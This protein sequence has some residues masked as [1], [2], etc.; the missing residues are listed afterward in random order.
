MTAPPVGVVLYGPPCSG[1]STITTAL[2]QLD[3]RFRLLRKLKA[4]TGRADEY[5]MVTAEQL[6]QLRRAGRL[7]IET[8]RY[9]NIYAVDRR[10][11]ED[12]T[13]AGHVP[14]VH[15]G[16]IADLRRLVG[17]TP[18]AWLRVL[19]WVPREVTERR[20]KDRGDTDTAE[21][22]RAWDETL[23]DLTAN[24]G[25]GFFHLRLCTD[26]LDVEAAAVEIIT[27]FHALTRAAEPRTAGCRQEDVPTPRTE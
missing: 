12:M 8:H 4:G 21:R 19:L 11:I 1:K 24:A 10:H 5:D 25:E 22:L 27:A 15:V 26:R 23:A 20:S 9:G 17:R 3:P 18:D 6:D 7:L 13:A 2:H 16:T 14:V